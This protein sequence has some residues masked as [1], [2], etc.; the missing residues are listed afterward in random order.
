MPIEQSAA[1]KISPNARCLPFPRITSPV[2]VL[3]AQRHV[4]T[5]IT[6]LRLHLSYLPDRSAGAVP[7]LRKGKR[8]KCFY[9][10]VRLTPFKHRFALLNE[11]LHA[12]FLVARGKQ[13]LIGFA[14]Q[15]QRRFQRGIHTGQHHFF[16]LHHRQRGHVG[17]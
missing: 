9:D 11:S 6:T 10:T 17:N 13:Q 5:S 2:G 12:F 14:L 4:T 8:K 1:K 3:R 16:D 15:H 7:M